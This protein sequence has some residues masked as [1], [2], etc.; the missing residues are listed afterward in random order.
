M[1]KRQKKTNNRKL[2]WLSVFFMLLTLAAL[3]VRPLNKT[4]YK[5]SDFCQ[6]TLKNIEFAQVSGGKTPQTF[7]AGWAKR[8]IT[9]DE[10][11]HLA[12]YGFRNKFSCVRDSSFVKSIVIKQGYKKILFV[13]FDLL[14]VHPDLRD[15]LKKTWT[16]KNFDFVYYTATHTHH[17]TGGWAKGLSGL[18]SG[19]FDENVFDFIIRQTIAATEDAEKNALPCRM[20]SGEFQTQ[21]MV[22]NRVDETAFT[23]EKMRFFVLENIKGKKILW[24]SFSA[25]PTALWGDYPCLSGDYTGDFVRYCERDKQTE[26]CIFAAG[27][28]ASHAPTKGGH[29]DDTETYG[30]EL[31]KM[32]STE[33]AAATIFDTLCQIS[34]CEADLQL[35]KPQFR[36]GDN[37]ALNDRIFEFVFG[38]LKGKIQVLQIGNLIFM[39]YPCDISGELYPRLSD[40]VKKANR[41]LIL[42]SFNGDYVGYVSNSAHYDKKHV[43]IRDM[44]WLGHDAFDF[45]EEISKKMLKKFIAEEKSKL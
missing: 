18:I 17:G 28:V 31:A 42:T 33:A 1:Q 38:E 9:P 22:R 10:P 20:A 41:Q 23:D 27:A 7:S 29:P 37:I 30:S 3:S 14:F 21:G 39:T 44:N 25:H 40:K 43:E 35:R 32:T 19:G 24:A 36:I 2:V 8:N 5:K 34:F 26:M 11:Q 6:E 15:A 12:G 13:N 45:F 16:D 4:S